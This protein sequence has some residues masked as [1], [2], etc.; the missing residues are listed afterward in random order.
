MQTTTR[1][2]PY[3]RTDARHHALNDAVARWLG[4][5]FFARAAVVNRGVD[6]V[7]LAHEIYVETGVCPRLTLPDYKLDHAKHSTE[8]QLLRFLLGLSGTGCQ[9][10]DGEAAGSSGTGCQPVFAPNSVLRGRFSMVPPLPAKLQPGDLVALQSG[11]I[12]HHLALVVSHGE[13]VHAV[14][15]YGVIRTP[16]DDPK[17]SARM[18]Y[19]LRPME[20]VESRK[21]EVEIQAGAVAPNTPTER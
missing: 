1:I 7:N 19:A 17:F 3:F 2:L 10:V 11:R 5:P 21:E 16:L 4:T 8:T 6:C 14:E 13:A 9:P 12:D 15:D 20:K 18:L